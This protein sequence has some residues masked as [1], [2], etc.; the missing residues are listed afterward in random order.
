MK[1]RIAGVTVPQDDVDAIVAFVARVE[2]SQRNALPDVFMSGFRQD[3]FWTTAHGKRLTGAE[4]IGA[5][6][7]RVLP[8]TVDDPVTASYRVEHILFIRPDIAAVK[9]RQRP[10]TRDGEALDEVFRGHEDPSAL[11]A[12]RPEAAPG[13]PLYVLAKDDGEWRIAAAQNTKVIDPET[14]ASLT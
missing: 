11:V 12:E 10:V 3:A 14:L 9:I 6:T 5:F 13:T 7:H 1:P 8:A 4:E 2:H